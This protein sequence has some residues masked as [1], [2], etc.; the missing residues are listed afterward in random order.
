MYFGKEVILAIVAAELIRER[1]H[2]QR[3]ILHNLE[4]YCFRIN[5]DHALPK[6]R[7]EERWIP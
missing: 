1:I 2:V 4:D 3:H 5:L 6:L 7:S